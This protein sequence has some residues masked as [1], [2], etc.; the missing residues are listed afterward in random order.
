MGAAMAS[1]DFVSSAEEKASAVPL[2][3]DD[4]DDTPNTIKRIDYDPDYQ[5][6]E[7]REDVRTIIR[8]VRDKWKSNPLRDD[9][10]GRFSTLDDTM[11]YRTL[12]TFRQSEFVR[13]VERTLAVAPIVAIA[14]LL[15]GQSGLVEWTVLNDARW[16]IGAWL[17]A[18]VILW[19][20][21]SVLDVSRT[22]LHGRL[23]LYISGIDRVTQEIKTDILEYIVRKRDELQVAQGRIQPVAMDEQSANRTREGIIGA[24]TAWRKMERLPFYLR[25]AWDL[26]YTEITDAR[27]SF[28]VESNKRLWRRNGRMLRRALTYVFALS[29][30][31]VGVGASLVAI[32]S[33]KDGGVVAVFEDPG[34]QLRFFATVSAALV[35]AS[36][37]LNVVAHRDRVVAT[38][39]AHGFGVK[40][41]AMFLVALGFHAIALTLGSGNEETAGLATSILVGFSGFWGLSLLFGLSFSNYASRLY[42]QVANLAIVRIMMQLR[43]H[44]KRK[45]LDSLDAVRV[46]RVSTILWLNNLEMPNHGRLP[47]A[48]KREVE[49]WNGWVP[50]S[51]TPDEDDDIVDEDGGLSFDQIVKSATDPSLYVGEEDNLRRIV[52]AS[53]PV[54]SLIETFPHIRRT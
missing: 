22:S 46:D 10:S 38:G 25:T 41:V 27:F 7:I 14:L 1:R 19:I 8:E 5:R 11:K 51:E 31:A 21:D 2:F 15:L 43:T 33:V 13:S 18:A 52:A 53:D 32:L 35:G 20:G 24:M 3:I 17:A 42:K 9:D 29:S 40:H 34:E 26:Y 6:A 12:S 49:S 23:N 48:P 54:E 28:E 37:A 30:A 36:Y 47:K 44:T 16:Q 4:D 45:M 50:S 39:G